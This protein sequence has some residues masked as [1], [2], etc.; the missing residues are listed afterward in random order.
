M[1]RQVRSSHRAIVRRLI[2]TAAAI[3]CLIGSSPA[4]LARALEPIVYDVR[5]VPESQ[6]ADV[7]VTIPTG[8]SASIDVMMPVWSPGFYR[9]EDYASRVQD[10]T[11]LTPDGQ[12][13]RCPSG[14]ASVGERSERF[15]VGRVQTHKRIAPSSERRAQMRLL[16]IGSDACEREDPGALRTHHGEPPN[17]P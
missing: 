3:A 12:W 2:V 14:A 11:A 5:L 16:R 6:T 10:V 13:F 8:K 4:H 9:V 1:Q 7:Q 17:G 15:L